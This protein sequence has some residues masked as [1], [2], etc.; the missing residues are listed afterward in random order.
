MEKTKKAFVTGAASGIGAEYCRQLDA[1]GYSLTLLGR[2]AAKLDAFA[3]TLS[4]PAKIIACD[5]MDHAS[6]SSML[7]EI[8]NEP[9]GFD[10][11]IPN[12]G[13]VEPCPVS[14]C[15][16]EDLDRHIITNQLS[17]MRIIRAV[18][19]KMLE[20]GSG[21]IICTVSM[22]GIIALENYAAYS[23]SK[24]GMRGFLWS[25]SQELKGT[26]VHV[27]GMYCSAVDT[28]MLK[29]EARH[30]YG[31]P[32][33]FMGKISSTKEVVAK[34]LTALDKPKLELYQPYGDSWTARILLFFPRFL[35]KLAP[36]LNGSGEKGR[37]KYLK[38]IEN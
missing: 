33:N 1:K 6:F 21:N 31:S 25:L 28:P 3:K 24:F 23:A 4:R 17:H 15:V 14:E 22:G 34:A 5:V 32:L 36:S 35:E 13:F 18:L 38:S 20:N 19:P 10:V 27:T 30:K 9:E 29:E 7:N 26:G 8:G 16:P 2:D 37:N 11:V 12:A